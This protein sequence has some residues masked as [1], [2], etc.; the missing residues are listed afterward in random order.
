MNKLSRRSSSRLSRLLEPIHTEPHALPHRANTLA[1]IRSDVRL[2]LLARE[3]RPERRHLLDDIL[4]M[5]IRLH[6]GD[7][8][9]QERDARLPALTRSLASPVAQG[10]PHSIR[11]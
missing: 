6:G 8:R 10:V 1:F 3:V 9:D 7:W 11:G 4:E 5:R 2:H